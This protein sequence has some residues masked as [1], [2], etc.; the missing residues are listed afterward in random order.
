[1]LINLMNCDLV[2]NNETL[3]NC[4]AIDI[5]SIVVN[6][7]FLFILFLFLFIFFN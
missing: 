3:I 2:M 1:M 4:F 7:L 6:V 5:S